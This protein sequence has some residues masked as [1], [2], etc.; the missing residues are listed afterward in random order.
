MPA[1]ATSADGAYIFLALENSSGQP[2]IVRAARSALSTFTAA[3]NPAAGSAGNVASVPGNPDLMLFYGNF[4]SGVQVVKHVISTGVNTNISPSGLTTK[5]ANALASNPSDP[6]EIW[7]TV[8]TDQDLKRSTDLGVGWA[9]LDAALGLNPTAMLALWSG[10]YNLDR[11]L[12]AGDVAGTEQLLYSANE[13]S[14]KLDKAGASLGAAA[15][16]VG[17]EGVEA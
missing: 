11:G 13:F 17:I 16:I 10:A 7:I 9:D 3:Y 14:S 5:V 15:A 6:N 12:I 8:N 4:G 2:V 1:I